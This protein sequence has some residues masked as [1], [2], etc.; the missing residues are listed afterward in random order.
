VRSHW[1]AKGL[2]FPEDYRRAEE[3]NLLRDI[4]RQTDE[5]WWVPGLVVWHARRAELK[6]VLLASLRGGYFR[7]RSLKEKGGPSW[8]W[9]APLFVVLHLSVIAMPPAFV[10]FAIS[11]LSLVLL[12]SLKLAAQARAWTLIPVMIF[13]HWSI[14]FSYGLGFIRYQMDRWG[15]GE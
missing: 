14:P 12:I 6:A 9:L 11:W 8:F 10:F 4:A 13:L 3:T 15:A 2:R 1:W 7:A 5:L